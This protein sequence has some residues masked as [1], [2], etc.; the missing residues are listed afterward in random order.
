MNFTTL[1]DL[2][3]YS[4]KKFSRIETFYVGYILTNHV[5]Y[6]PTPPTACWTLQ[7]RG[8]AD[9]PVRRDWRSAVFRNSFQAI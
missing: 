5:Y 8:P 1:L 9:Y 4:L 7:G 6:Y 3:F 2:I